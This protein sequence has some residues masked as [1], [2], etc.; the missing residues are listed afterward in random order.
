VKVDSFVERI[1]KQANRP[2]EALR[3]DDLMGGIRQFAG[4]FHGELVAETMLIHAIND[5]E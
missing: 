2:H 5:T 1:W 3:L 4:Q